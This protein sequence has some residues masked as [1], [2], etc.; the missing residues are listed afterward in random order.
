MSPAPFAL[1]AQVWGKGV[2]WL[3][4][5]TVRS[6]GPGIPQQGDGISPT[7][8]AKPAAAKMPGRRGG[9]VVEGARLESV[10]TGDRN[11]GSNPALSASSLNGIQLTVLATFSYMSQNAGA[12][13]WCPKKGGTPTWKFVPA[14]RLE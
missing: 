4:A 10:F 3:T 12:P 14:L 5:P 6:S 8:A 9:R 1:T 7:R 11:A 13:S 2:R